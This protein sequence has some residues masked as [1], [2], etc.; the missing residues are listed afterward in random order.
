MTRLFIAL[1]ERRNCDKWSKPALEEGT[2][3]EK[4]ETTQEMSTHNA[5]QHDE[6]KI[7]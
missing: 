5:Q 3:I 4:R 7:G 1:I 6:R 2:E